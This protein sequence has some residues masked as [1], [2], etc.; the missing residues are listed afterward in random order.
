MKFVVIWNTLYLLNLSSIQ[1]FV[2]STVAHMVKNLPVVG[3]PRF[4]SWVLKIL[5]GREWLPIPVFLPGE[6]HGQRRLLDYSP[7]G[8][9]ESDMTERLT[10]Q[11]R[12]KHLHMSTVTYTEQPPWLAPS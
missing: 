9:K 10:V 6:F 3:R 11:T 2:L 1:I 8:H 5:W 12:S 4:D 7:W